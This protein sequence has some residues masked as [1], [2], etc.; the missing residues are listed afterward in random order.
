MIFIFGNW[1]YEQYFDKKDNLKLST[2]VELMFHVF[3]KDSFVPFLN[4]IAPNLHT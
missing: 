2:I 3:S 1:T 4:G